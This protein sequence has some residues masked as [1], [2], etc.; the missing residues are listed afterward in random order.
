MKYGLSMNFFLELIIL[1]SNLDVYNVS[2]IIEINVIKV[3][4]LSLHRCYGAIKN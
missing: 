4:I 3:V 1:K 2:N